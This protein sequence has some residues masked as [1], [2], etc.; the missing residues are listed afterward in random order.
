MDV[1]ELDWNSKLHAKLRK[2][3]AFLLEHDGW[4]GEYFRYSDLDDALNILCGYDESDDGMKKVDVQMIAEAFNLKGDCA[5]WDKLEFPNSQLTEKESGDDAPKRRRSRGRNTSRPNTPEGGEE[6]IFHF[7]RCFDNKSKKREYKLGCVKKGGGEPKDIESREGGWSPPHL[8]ADTVFWDDMKAQLRK[9]LVERKTKAVRNKTLNTKRS[10][11]KNK[12]S[13]LSTPPEAATRQTSAATST[14]YTPNAKKAKG[15]ATAI[16]SNNMSSVTTEEEDET[17]VPLQPNQS[18]AA[19]VDLQSLLFD[20]TSN[21]KESVVK[22]LMENLKSKYDKK[23]PLTPEE[24][25]LLGGLAQCEMKSNEKKGS[26]SRISSIQ[27]IYSFKY[28]PSFNMH[29]EPQQYNKDSGPKPARTVKRHTKIASEWMNLIAGAGFLLG[30]ILDQIK[31]LPE[32]ARR[33]ISKVTSYC[34]SAKETAA[35]KSY[36]NFNEEQLKRLRRYMKYKFGFR[37]FASV[38]SVNKL[39]EDYFDSNCRSAESKIVTMQRPVQQTKNGPNVMTRDSLVM[40]FLIRPLDHLISMMMGL[41]RSG[42]FKS[43]LGGPGKLSAQ[44]KDKAVVKGAGDAGGGSTKLNINSCNVKN[45]QGQEHQLVVGASAKYPCIFNRATLADVK[46]MWDW[47]EEE[48]LPT[49]PARTNANIDE[50]YARYVRLYDNAVPSRKTSKLRTSVTQNETHS[51][52]MPRA[53]SCPMDAVIPSSMHA[54]LG[55]SRSLLDF[56]FDFFGKIAKLASGGIHDESKE[57]IERQIKHLQV[58]LS[59]LDSQQEDVLKSLEAKDKILDDILDTISKYQKVVE[60]STLSERTRAEYQS[61]LADV[62]Q[63]YDNLI[64]GDADETA[65]EKQMKVQ[66]LEQSCL[67]QNTID[68][69]QDLYKHHS[70]FSQVIIVN[71]LREHKV[72]IQVYF[73][74]TLIGPHCMILA[75]HSEKIHRA[76]LTEMQKKVTDPRLNAAMIKYTNKIIKINAVWFELCKTMKSTDYQDDA[77]IERFESN[78]IKLRSLIVDLVVTDPPLPGDDYPLKLPYKLKWFTLLSDI[79]VKALKVWRCIGDVDEESIESFHPRRNKMSRRYCQTRGQHRNELIMKALQ[80]ESAEWIHDAIQEM[81][82][83]TKAKRAP[84]VRDVE[85]QQDRPNEDSDDTPAEQEENVSMNDTLLPYEMEMNANEAL[86]IPSD[87]E[88]ED[89]DLCNALKNMNTKICAC[90]CGL[91][92]IGDVSLRIHQNERHNNISE[93]N[94]AVDASVR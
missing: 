73:N 22:C 35:L 64:Q 74:G 44:H 51:I 25:R 6:Y 7:Y 65:E 47:S 57:A 80:F 13:R 63:V 26:S 46:K 66:L 67:V 14:G 15:N 52:S 60:A 61:K 91:R 68:S 16:S 28:F 11:E 43:R 12:A 53:C 50:D 8:T 34:L 92:F 23:A 69:L 5:G 88:H 39:K 70:C 56:D 10:L 17:P 41:L 58:Y 45:P 81:L 4:R 86:R 87:F 76:I 82:E 3:V 89:E 83:A 40:V 33:Q 30:F 84:I 75:E 55:G 9:F 59:E 36:C 93:E 19:D 62:Q 78:L 71:T 29:R 38:G 90:H 85:Q 72:D 42:K 27:G 77:A 79:M 24:K 37:L 20:E 18:E 2:A 54:R 49:Y 1:I 48:G 32:S 94:D 31:R 21:M